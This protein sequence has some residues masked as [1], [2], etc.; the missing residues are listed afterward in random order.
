MI[1][2]TCLNDFRVGDVNGFGKKSNDEDRT[3]TSE[4]RSGIQ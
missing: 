1:S 3:C 4:S 2:L